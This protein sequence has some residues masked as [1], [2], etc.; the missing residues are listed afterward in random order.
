MQPDGPRQR[1]E[2]ART[3][4]DFT[5][6]RRSSAQPVDLNKID[7]DRSYNPHANDYDNWRYG[8]YYGGGWWGNPYGYGY[9]GSYGYGHGHCPGC[10]HYGHGN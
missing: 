2:A 1:A 4:E 7:D 6:A 10:G 9:E 5:V 3:G 8:G